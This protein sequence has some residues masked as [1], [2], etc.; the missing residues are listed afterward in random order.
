[1]AAKQVKKINVNVDAFMGCIQSEI[2]EDEMAEE[3][4]P[5]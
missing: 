4:M 3:F 5:K 1:M 2:V